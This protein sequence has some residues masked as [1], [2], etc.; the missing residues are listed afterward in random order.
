MLN[1][2]VGIQ[3]IFVLML[4]NRSFDHMLGFSGIAGTDAVTGAP[5][6][7]DGLKGTESNSLNGKPYSVSRGASNIMPH[8]PAHE[9]A[10]VVVQLCGPGATYHGGPYPAIQN[11]GFVQSY[12]SHFGSEPANHPG[13]VMNC[14][15]TAKELPVLQALAQEFVVCDN[16]R[17]SMPGPTWPNRLFVHAASSGG[18]DHSP[19]VAEIVLW[20]SLQGFGFKNGTI[21]DAF[22][23]AGIPRRLYAGDDFPLVSALKGITLGDIRHYSQFASDLNGPTYDY[24]YVLIEPSYDALND[25]KNGDSQHPLGDVTQGEALI[26]L[27]YEAIRNSPL[28]ENSL[29]VIVWDE[30]GGFYDGGAPPAPAVAPGDTAP[31]SEHNQT[32]FTFEQYGARVPAIVISPRIPKNLIDHRLYD[33]SS[34]PATVEALCGLKPLTARD[35]AANSL[36]HLISLT[37]ARTDAPAK[38]PNPASAPA[39]QPVSA[40]TP[41]PAAVPTPVA[42]PQDSASDGNVPAVV[43]AALRQ[44]LEVSPP[45]QRPAILARAAAIKT[46]QQAAQY[47]DAV[48]AKVRGVRAAAPG[49]PRA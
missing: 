19:S 16:W 37:A 36:H 17:A 18:L 9:F 2:T 35:A 4:E 8:D 28:W 3:H 14:Y 7:I 20:E 21:F 15:D 49:T 46:R 26:K 5:T 22:Q 29:L 43:H 44:E 1:N 11:S 23:K 41:Q 30:H 10:D 47:L 27:T 40:L 31:G 12:A 39:S 32:G 25:Y 6:G 48:R 13:D 33:H 42:R 24:N 34:I 45:E 38:L